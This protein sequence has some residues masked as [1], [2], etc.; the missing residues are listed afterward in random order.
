MPT[1]IPTAATG[2]TA[3]PG[4]AVYVD[5]ERRWSED[6]V[7]EALRDSRVNGPFI[8]DFLSAVITHERC[9]VHLYRSVAGRTQNPVL[10]SRYED[11][12]A[13]SERHVQ[14]LEHAITE[15]G[16]DPQ[17]VSPSARAT[18]G[19]DTKLVESTFLLGGS[20]DVMQR[21]MAMLDAVLAAESLDRAN[22]EAIA[23]LIDRLPEGS[24]RT[25]LA[26][27]CAEVIDQEDAHVG[28]ALETRT[29]MVTMQASSE[30][31][32]TI[33]AKAEELAERVRGW[34]S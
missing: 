14:L 22:W 4:E 7:P 12:G 1:L 21:E 9:A 27:A 3:R 32:A 26:G 30:A 6:Q 31:M 2:A 24:G 28:W 29:K 15:L 20:L 23:K 19:M 11:F 18:E 17:H 10:R 33:G 34:F 16:A 25:A 13:E 8:L 5:P